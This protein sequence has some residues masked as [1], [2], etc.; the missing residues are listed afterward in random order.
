[1]GSRGVE[2]VRAPKRNAPGRVTEGVMACASEG[3]AKLNEAG[4]KAGMGRK[5]IAD[6]GKPARP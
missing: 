4:L 3:H 6:Q 2:A 1:M 5:A